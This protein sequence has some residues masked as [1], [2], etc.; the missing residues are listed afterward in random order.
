MSSE[1]VSEER[2]GEKDEVKRDI[3]IL[4]IYVSNFLLNLFI[5]LCH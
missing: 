5:I 3:L 2:E 1:G 4:T